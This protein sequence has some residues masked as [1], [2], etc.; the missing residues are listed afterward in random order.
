M[1]DRR[2]VGVEPGDW[3]DSGRAHKCRSAFAMSL[4]I[5]L[6]RVGAQ[7]GS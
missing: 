5:R 4:P 7:F 3:S 6:V 2:T 1:R